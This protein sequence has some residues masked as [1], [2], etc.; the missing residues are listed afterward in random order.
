[1]VDQHKGD[2]DMPGPSDFGGEVILTEEAQLTTQA[3]IA[4]LEAT[5]DNAKVYKLIDSTLFSGSSDVF[6]TAVGGYW[7]LES[8]SEGE[9]LQFQSY[10]G[11]QPLL[12]YFDKIG[13]NT[14]LIETVSDDVA[15]LNKRMPIRV[16]G[17]T[18]VENDK[19]WETLFVGGSYAGETYYPIYNEKLYGYNY[20]VSSVPYTK[21]EAAV[22][23][24]GHAIGDQVQITFKYNKYLPEYQNYIRALGS[25][26]L[27][28]NFY[29]LADVQTYDINEEDTHRFSEKIVDF[30]TL[31]GDY[32]DV[33]T[34]LT[35]DSLNGYL[36]SS[37]VNA[38]MSASTRTYMRE[39][40][41]NIFLD[42][43]FLNKIYNTDRAP[44]NYAHM[45]PCYTHISFPLTKT[46]VEIA[47][48]E[49]QHTPFLDSII[50]N[51]YTNRFLKTL[52]EVFTGEVASTPLT[53]SRNVSNMNYV[54]SSEGDTVDHNVET[55][56][57]INVKRYD[58][59]KFL[60]YT[61]N[62][63][64]TTTD[65]NYF[66]GKKNVYRDGMSDKIGAYRYANSVGASK[67][68]ADAMKFVSD[69]SNFEITGLKN[70]LYQNEQGA[71]NEVLAYRIEKVGGKPTGTGRKQNV[72]Q[73]YWLINSND[74]ENFD[75]YDTQI[76]YN[77][78]YT[79][80]V[81][82]YML[83]AGVR[84]KFSDLRVTKAISANN[85]YEGAGTTF[86]GL[87]FYDPKTGD[88]VDQL[89]NTEDSDGGTFTDLNSLGTLVQEKSSWPYLADFYLNYEPCLMVYEVPVFSK[90]IRVLDNPPNKMS[91]YPYQH[92]DASRKIGFRFNYE[93]P[94][95][96]TFPTTITPADVVL[97][98]HYVNSK[99]LLSSD[100]LDQYTVS[101]PRYIQVFRT[102]ERPTKY[103]DFNKKL[104]KTVDLKMKNS[105]STH[106][107]DFFD[108]RI[109]TNKKYYYLFR[110]LNE[111]R[112]IGH[113]SEIYEVQLVNDGGYLYALFNIIHEEQLEE[114]VFNNPSKKF[115]KLIQLQPN[116][117]QLSLD[118]T[119]VDFEQ[120]AI[121]QIDNIAVGSAEDLIW[122]KTFKVRLTSKKTGKKIDLNITY[123]LRRQTIAD[124]SVEADVSN[125]DNLS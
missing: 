116:L 107:V 98:Q 12:P 61:Y 103:T 57:S 121:T 83:V 118:T 84:Y 104:I 67:T 50:D 26:K 124:A 102:D 16:Y 4:S 99:D 60:S 125:S 120:D 66:M 92:V 88:K 119:N 3:E 93:S 65:N 58:Y 74:L 95:D 10:R 13:S 106:T 96:R 44:A 17:N 105:K 37:Y 36:S 73:N 21:R 20:F 34:A 32:S 33:D 123:N 43:T 97:K 108:Q 40:M 100:T 22:T 28:P 52:K 9:A 71:H 75:F 6:R 11:D 35:T 53:I 82:A 59:F 115:K 5:T 18:T 55:N 48:I 47:G 69:P 70:F 41:Q 38:E 122:D 86:Y 1:M 25:E 30:L 81:Y 39:K 45:F 109:R 64:N 8:G 112:M 87:E 80:N 91:I 15:I 111:Q 90:A 85:E 29:L 94:H 51:K 23:S 117:S 19:F 24:I 78:D 27:I 42:N 46:R 54:S 31:E 76:K 89:Y 114:K 2:I 68:F 49:Q 56:E 62:Q 7:Y 63:F 14:E 101:R 79:Y 77:R 110:A 72:L 113:T